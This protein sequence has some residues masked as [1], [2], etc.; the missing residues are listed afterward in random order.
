MGTR[1]RQ[2]D[3]EKCV[4]GIQTDCLYGRWSVLLGDPVRVR[5][6]EYW[7]EG[8]H[9]RRY[10]LPK[11]KAVRTRTQHSINCALFFYWPGRTIVRRNEL[12]NLFVQE[13]VAICYAYLL[14]RLISDKV[15]ALR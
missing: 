8:I 9:R 12:K 1:V 2:T 13:H 14:A 6:D 5:G 15:I 3:Q 11:P 7:R 10:S 4:L